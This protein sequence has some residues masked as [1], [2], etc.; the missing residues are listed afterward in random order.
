[1]SDVYLYFYFV[2]VTT[3]NAIIV[4]KPHQ[5]NRESPSIF[6]FSAL[7]NSFDQLLYDFETFSDQI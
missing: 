5:K 3:A 6:G 2:Y 1:M 7:P 4:V